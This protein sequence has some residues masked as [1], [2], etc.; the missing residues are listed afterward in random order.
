MDEKNIYKE[1]IKR[2]NFFY[3]EEARNRDL[4]LSECAVWACVFRHFNWYTGVAAVSYGRIA[5]DLGTSPSTARR[6]L[7][8]L[9]KK[10][11]LFRI[12]KGT[13]C[14]L[15]QFAFYDTHGERYAY[16]YKNNKPR[17]SADG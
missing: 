14:T 8:G 4:T 7:V 2:L 9:C 10:H 11:A 3:D 6:A 17:Y 5:R 12:R 15:S 1:R 16:N 13:S